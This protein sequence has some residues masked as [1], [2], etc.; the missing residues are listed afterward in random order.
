VRASSRVARRLW[1]LIIGQNGGR[2]RV[3]GSDEGGGSGSSRQQDFRLFNSAWCHAATAG[4]SAGGQAAVGALKKGVNV[5]LPSQRRPPRFPHMA[6][7]VQPGVAVRFFGDG[8]P[9]RQST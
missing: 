1:C 9:L 8:Q 3:G 4:F 7:A 6:H 5:Q 2:I